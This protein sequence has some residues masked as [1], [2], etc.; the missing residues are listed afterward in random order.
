MEVAALV[1]PPNQGDDSGVPLMFPTE[2]KQGVSVFRTHAHIASK[3]SPM[4]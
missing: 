3:A 1:E 4:P 2:E